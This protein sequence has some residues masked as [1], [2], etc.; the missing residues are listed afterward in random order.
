MY[1]GTQKCLVQAQIK[2]EYAWSSN[3][4]F[5]SYILHSLLQTISVNKSKHMAIH[6]VWFLQQDIQFAANKVFNTDIK[7]I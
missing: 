2:L 6:L 1:L 7:S 3:M 4:L 5:K